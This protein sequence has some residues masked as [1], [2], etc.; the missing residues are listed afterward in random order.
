[1]SYFGDGASNIG[2][3]HE[4]LNMASAWKLPVVFVCQ[5][6][7]YAEHSAFA[8]GTSAKCVADRAASYQMPGIAVDGND[9][10]AMWKAA[11]AAIDRARGGDGPTLIEANTFRLE[12][13]N[14]GDNNEYMAAGEL[15]AARARDPVPKL[16]ASL[17]ERGIATEAQLAEIEAQIERDNDEAAAFAFASEFAGLDELRRDVYAEEL[18]P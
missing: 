8:L 14:M 1:V 3:F 13:H 10:A 6:N 7:Q 17:L 4:A 16:R 15:A 12:G 9:P 2:A 18:T 11:R 5:N